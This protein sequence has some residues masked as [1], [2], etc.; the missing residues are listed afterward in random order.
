MA[1][2]ASRRT[3]IHRRRILKTDKR[4]VTDRPTFKLS[5]EAFSAFGYAIV[6]DD[7]FTPHFM[8][9]VKTIA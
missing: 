2:M 5:S 3:T 8:P 9:V 6:L 1:D 4:D 7:L